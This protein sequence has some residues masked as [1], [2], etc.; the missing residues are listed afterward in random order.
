[1]SGKLKV[2]GIIVI[3]LAVAALA[4]S[5]AFLF[6]GFSK[7]MFI[8]NSMREENVKL[9]DLGITGPKAG[10]LIDD[11]ET[12]QIAADTIRGHRRLIA[13]SYG[14]LLGA[15]KFDPTNPT[16]LKYAQAVNLENYLYMGVLGL[17]VTTIAEAMGGFM[18]IVAVALGIIGCLLVNMSK[19]QLQP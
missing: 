18:L 16:D 5:T 14:A 10:R 15:G 19:K 1:M 4:M 13:S 17:G 11:A 9:G 7:Q 8:E 6:E 2:S 3:L 12:A